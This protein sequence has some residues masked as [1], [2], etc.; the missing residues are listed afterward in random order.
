MTAP[1]IRY[2]MSCVLRR[3]LGVD[4]TSHIARCATKRLQRNEQARFYHH[5]ARNRLAPKRFHE[6]R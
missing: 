4:R 3:R 2:I 6:R 5:K 1:Q